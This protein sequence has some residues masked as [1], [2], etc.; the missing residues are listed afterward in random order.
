MSV[1]VSYKHLFLG[2][3]LFGNYEKIDEGK[4]DHVCENELAN[5]RDS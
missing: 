4:D 2:C 5:L 1:N 3:N